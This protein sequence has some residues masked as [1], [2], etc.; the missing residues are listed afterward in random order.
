MN[1][2]FLLLV[3]FLAFSLTIFGQNDTLDNTV[4]PI[5]DSFINNININPPNTIDFD[6]AF[7]YKTQVQTQKLLKNLFLGGFI[8]MTLVVIFLFYVNQTKIK[9]VL[10]LLKIQEREI[11]IRRFE[12]E[13]LSS[14][15]NNTM[16]AVVIIDK[17][18]KLLWNNSSFL[19]VYG[20]TNE[21]LKT[22]KVD[23][24]YFEN[25]EISS[26]IEKCKKEIK[27]I[28][29]TFEHKN[30]ENLKINIQR[31]I[32]PITDQHSDDVNYAIIDT[33]YTALKLATKK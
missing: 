28:E 15:L 3:L 22:N 8:F 7:L 11:K 31:R 18:Q 1:S 12:V 23:F 17:D 2:K 27:P 21:E 9:Q 29:F 20:Y 6:E 24:F 10:G 4:Y 16:D 19:S 5:P 13:K 25:E 26:L 14:I 32:I 30:K 33:D